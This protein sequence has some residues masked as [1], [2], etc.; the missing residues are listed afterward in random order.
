MAGARQGKGQQSQRLVEARVKAAKALD[1]RIL[2]YTY[3][4]IAEQVGYNSHQ[5]AAKAIGSALK[6]L[7]KEPAEEV[8]KLELRRLDLMQRRLAARVTEGDEKA[9]DRWLAIMAH[10]A[11]LLGLA[12]PVKAEIVADVKAN[13]K[14]EFKLEPEFT[15]EVVRILA[16]SGVTVGVPGKADLQ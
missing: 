4:Q 5:A 7:E 11:R 2:G 16:E 12:A 10:R 8:R 14:T 1:A 13:V 3:E 6:R 15:A 9:H